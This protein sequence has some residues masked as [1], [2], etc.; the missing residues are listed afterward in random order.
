MAEGR[1]GEREGRGER[2]EGWRWE[3]EAG[4]LLLCVFIA[5]HALSW[6]DIIYNG[7][8]EERKFSAFFIK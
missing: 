8:P 7:E 2:E 1:R 5:G 6:D 4:S 3:G